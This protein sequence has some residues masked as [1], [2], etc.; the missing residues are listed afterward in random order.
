M[1]AKAGEAQTVT[2]VTDAIADA[3][4]A[5]TPAECANYLRN[6]GYAAA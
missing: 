2:G 5:F 3:L 1:S 6:T 4:D